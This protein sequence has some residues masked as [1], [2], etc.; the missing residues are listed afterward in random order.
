MSALPM[1]FDAA[2]RAF[3]H[4]AP[5]PLIETVGRRTD[6]EWEEQETRRYAIEAIVLAMPAD[7]L[8]LHKEGDS[9]TAG[10]ILHTKETLFFTDI[11]NSGQEQRQSYVEYQGCRFRVT[12]TGFLKGNANFNTY[13]A[14]RHF[15]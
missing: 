2:L 13:E 1:N 4:P 8:E 10:I 14:V 3:R 7:K 11:N 6:G 15:T 9:S 5:L 12:G